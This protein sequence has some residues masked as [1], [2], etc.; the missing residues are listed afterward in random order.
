VL[1]ERMRFGGSGI[2]KRCVQQLVAGALYCVLLPFVLCQR[3]RSYSHHPHHQLPRLFFGATS[4]ITLPNLA[5][6]LRAQGY[7]ALSGAVADVDFKV[8]DGFDR[9]VGCSAS[10][11]MVIRRLLGTVEAM[12][13]FIWAIGRADI[14]HL[15]LDGGFLRRT[16]LQLYEL[17]LLKM[18]G[19]KVIVFPYGHDSWALDRI[20]DPTYRAALLADYPG[21]QATST[22]VGERL[23][24]FCREADVVVG[25][26]C[27]IM[28]LPRF[29]SLMMTC[30]GV[31]TDEF[32]PVYPDPRD[33]ILR[34]FHAPNHRNCKGSDFLEQAVW[35][36]QAEG[37][38]IEL[39]LVQKQPRIEVLRRMAQAHVLVDQLLAG[40][41]MTALEGMA[42]GK[43][44]ITGRNW[45][46][47]DAPFK[48]FAPYVECP[49]H[50]ADPATIKQ[51]LRDI[52]RD[53]EQWQRWGKAN[54]RFVERYHSPAAM[55]GHWTA[56]Y[57]RLGFSPRRIDSASS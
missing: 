20:P 40:Y 51:T 7:D 52:A 46:A 30:Y 19:K 1:G 12:A 4:I 23:D 39:D 15:Y 21:L 17:K 54:R 9:V 26:L 27:H 35:D 22:T 37:V 13:A 14:F 57:P 16:P 5:T 10:R 33:Y 56:L 32:L 50:W 43:I 18:A 44:V 28:V 34:V 45:P 53:R 25:C 29:D 38:N 49:V 41:G 8:P 48:D 36:L 47:A 11:N 31:E 6:A 42:L 3:W 2:L 24:R 55:A